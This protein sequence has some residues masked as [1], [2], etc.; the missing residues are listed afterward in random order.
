MNSIPRWRIAAGIFV[1][2]GL[3]FFLALFAPYYFR[4][5]QLQ[6]YVSEMTH[7]VAA[8]P[9]SDDVLRTRVVEEAR[10]LSLPVSDDNVRI[11]HTG[12]GL[13]VDVRYSVSINLPGYAVK[14]HFYPGAGSR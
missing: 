4:N 6:T 3:V 5:L 14:L 8:G 13:Q 12:D 9:P 10:R 2:A 1:L 7:R 11:S